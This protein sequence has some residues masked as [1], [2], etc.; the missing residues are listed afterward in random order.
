M[1]TP[2]KD[3]DTKPT[4]RPDLLDLHN[5]LR[6]VPTNSVQHDALLDLGY[7]P[8]ESDDVDTT[9]APKRRATDDRSGGAVDVTRHREHERGVLE[10]IAAELVASG[11]PLD[12]EALRWAMDEFRVRVMRET[13]V[14]RTAVTGR[15]Q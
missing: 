6:R 15:I 7:V 1:S 3:D 14:P 12:G 10:Q 4:R 13:N 11:R 9:L 8:V 5:G 2:T